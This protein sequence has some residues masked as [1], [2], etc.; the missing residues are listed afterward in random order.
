MSNTR[1]SIFGCAALIGASIILSPTP[2]DAKC[3]SYDVV[4]KSK[5]AAKKAAEATKRSAEAAKRQADAAA[6]ATAE[7]TRRAA[8]EAA[9]KSEELRRQ[10]ATAA[11]AAQKA[12]EKAAA[13]AEATAK[14]A[15]AAAQAEAKAAEKL[16]ADAAAEAKKQTEAAAKATTDAARKAAEAA[17]KTAENVSKEAE[18]QFGNAKKTAGSMAKK[19]NKA[20]RNVANQAKRGF[21]HA[22]HRFK[23][24]LSG[25]LISSRVCRELV[26]AGLN[27]KKLSRPVE[28][29][30]RQMIGSKSKSNSRKHKA[31]ASEQA[32]FKKKFEGSI[33]AGTPFDD[34]FGKYAKNSKRKLAAFT[35]TLNAKDLCGG[36]SADYFFAKLR[37]SGLYPSSKELKKLALNGAH[38]NRFALHDAIFPPAAAST[39]GNKNAYGEFLGVALDFDIAAIGGLTVGFEWIEHQAKTGDKRDNAKAT[40]FNWGYSVGPAFTMDAAMTWM[41]YGCKMA[42]S[43]QRCRPRQQQARVNWK[44]FPGESRGLE[45]S[46]NIGAGASYTTVYPM[47]KRNKETTQPA[48][49]MSEKPIGAGMGVG[50]GFGASIYNTIWNHTYRISKWTKPRSNG[51]L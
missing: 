4:C 10:A 49:I 29:A 5:E 38:P 25:N 43:G 47:S 22:V 19:V 28:I 21:G 3:K 44:S 33:G 31:S 11:D 48:I 1:N 12:A 18:K 45:I 32:E 39:V 2:A 9:A 36:K 24:E 20:G 16:L 7:A 41:K 8:A 30:M 14:A 35:K 26:E 51:R 40:Y 6:R 15:A 27:K 37:K 34:V 50:V 42:A 17:K 46:V 13:Q 23:R